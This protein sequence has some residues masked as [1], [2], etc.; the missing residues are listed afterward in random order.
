MIYIPAIIGF[1]ILFSLGAAEKMSDSVSLIVA[2][3]CFV[4]SIILLMFKKF[5]KTPVY[6]VVL[7]SMAFGIFYFS[8]Y[9]QSIS[10]NALANGVYIV[11][12]E[13]S[14]FPSE[15]NGKFY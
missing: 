4:M 9:S 10:S 14:Q 12:G 15:N 11:E 3:A 8:F 5:R 1:S 13:I 7:L 6:S 2:A